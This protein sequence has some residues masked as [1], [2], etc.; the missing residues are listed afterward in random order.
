MGIPT[1]RTSQQSEDGALSE[2]KDQ[3]SSLVD[4]AASTHE[5]IQITRHR[6][7]VLVLMSAVHLESLQETLVSLQQPA[8]RE[9]L[10][11]PPV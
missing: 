1:G 7:P 5:M 2:A 3:L 11:L 6:R 9:D 10:G 4:E 8:V